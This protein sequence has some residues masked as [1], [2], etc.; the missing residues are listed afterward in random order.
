[1]SMATATSINTQMSV[2]ATGGIGGGDKSASGE[3]SSDI[4]TLISKRAGEQM[5]D[6]Y[7]S[8]ASAGK[9]QPST[10]GNGVAGNDYPTMCSDDTS[11]F[12][13]SH[14]HDQTAMTSGTLLPP[15]RRRKPRRKNGQRHRKPY[16]P[17]T[18]SSGASGYSMES[19]F[20]LPRVEEHVVDLKQWPVLGIDV[21]CQDGGVFISR[22]VA[23][24][25]AEKCGGI[26]VGD[27]IVQVKLFR[28]DLLRT[29]CQRT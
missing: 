6:I 10:N 2:S 9:P 16:V 1:M 13:T 22:V 27:Q 17:S 15:V 12:F 14:H 20:S 18:I 25:A 5:A 28:S 19:S 23:G 24:S 4:N 7:T 11:A 8:E 26:E 3:A 21:A 29:N